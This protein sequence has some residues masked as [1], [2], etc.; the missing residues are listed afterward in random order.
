MNFIPISRFTFTIKIMRDRSGT[1]N[2]VSLTIFALWRKFGQETR[3]LV[4]K[5]KLG[6]NRVSLTILV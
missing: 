6:R 4:S 5:L 1:R 3:F 2:R